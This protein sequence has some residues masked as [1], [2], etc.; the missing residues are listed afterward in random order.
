MEKEEVEIRI[1][2]ELK[3]DFTIGKLKKSLNQY[4]MNSSQDI[5]RELPHLGLTAYVKLIDSTHVIVSINGNKDW[6]NLIELYTKK[7]IGF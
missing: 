2:H 6:Y 4:L 3:L 7:S 1:Q 5:Q